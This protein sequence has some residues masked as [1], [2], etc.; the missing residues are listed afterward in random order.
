[1]AV[2]SEQLDVAHAILRENG[3]SVEDYDCARSHNAFQQAISESSVSTLT[4]QT[5]RCAMI[6]RT[7]IDV[8]CSLLVQ[9]LDTIQ[10]IKLCGCMQSV[11]GFGPTGVEAEAPAPKRS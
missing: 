10:T 5:Q 2:F 8:D 11:R 3:D 6:K 1:M 9:L 4:R 7:R